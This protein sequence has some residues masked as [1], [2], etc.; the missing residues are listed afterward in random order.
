MFDTFKN[1]ITMTEGDYGVSLPIHFID[2]GFES[3]D[4]IK[5]T[6]M[7]DSD[8][9]IEKTYTEIVDDTIDFSLTEAESNLLPVGFYL[10]SIEWYQDGVFKDCI[11]EKSPFVVSERV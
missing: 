7:V 4:S 3:N 8:T 6:I 1:K 11:L 5:V 10:Y 9:S 2:A